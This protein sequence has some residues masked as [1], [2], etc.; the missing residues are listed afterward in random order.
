MST[1]QW[2]M[3]IRSF[4]FTRHEHP[5]GEE[6]A[7]ARANLAV[8]AEG[9][10]AGE[11]ERE[12]N[13]GDH[14]AAIVAVEPLGDDISHEPDHA[15]PREH[16]EREAQAPPEVRDRVGRLALE[17]G[18]QRPEQEP[19]GPGEAC[20]TVSSCQA[21]GTRQPSTDLSCRVAG[22]DAEAAGG[23]VVVG[24]ASSGYQ[25][26][27][28]AERTRPNLMLIDI[29]LPGMSG[30]AIASALLNAVPGQSAILLSEEVDRQNLRPGGGVRSGRRDIQPHGPGSLVRVAGSA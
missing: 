11:E 30:Y 25:A 29:D 20:A 28:E 10:G 16:E 19:V 13:A 12:E 14:R 24:E 15:H 17:R 21:G 7:H 27:Q 18:D 1:G 26:M 6:G 5:G 22:G 23:F 3:Y 9:H 2:K 4:T 8:G